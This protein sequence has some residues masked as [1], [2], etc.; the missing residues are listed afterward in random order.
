MFARANPR[1]ARDAK[2]RRPL[3][4]F[5]RAAVDDVERQK[6]TLARWLPNYAVPD[7]VVCTVVVNDGNGAL[8][9]WSQAWPVITSI[10]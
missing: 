1:P 3:T 5:A 9:L 6:A 8:T 10:S 2:R 4:G 7:V